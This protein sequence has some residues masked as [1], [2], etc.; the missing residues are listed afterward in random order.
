M[1]YTTK[2]LFSLF[3]KID[4]RDK[5]TAGKK[6]LYGILIAYVFSNTILAYNYF[7][8]FD[9]RSFVILTLTSNLFLI[10]IIVLSDFDNLLLANKSFE[11]LTTLPII[12]QQLFFSKFLSAVIFLMLFIS[13]S[14][15]P[16]II[17][18]Y[19][20]EHDFLKTAAYIF[21]NIVFSYFII[22][23]LIFIYGIV[24]NY[25]TSKASIVLAFVQVIFFIFVLYSS[26]LSSR[27]VATSKFFP[28]E[29]ILEYELMNFL[30]QTLFANAVYNSNY[31]IFCLSITSVILYLVYLFLS[32]KYFALINKLNSIGKKEKSGAGQRFTFIK[33]Y[34]LHRFVL[35][36]NYEVSSFN[37]ALYQLRNSRFLKI[38]YIPLVLIPILLV[39][40][41]ILSDIPQLLILNQTGKQTFFTTA[42]F[43]I[44]PSIT[45]TLIMSSRLLISN[46]KI[47]DENTSNTEWIYDSLP[48]GNKKIFIK[49]SVKF[50]YLYF[51]LPA[52]VTIL[53]LLS[54]NE[55]FVIVSLNILFIISALYL[56]SSISLLFDKIYPFTLESNKLKSASKFI[57]I[58]SALILGMIL[59]LI[60]IFVF[61]NII[62]V[63]I[64]I[65]F[66]ITLT[67]LINRNK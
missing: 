37:L 47:L 19:F 7:V 14:A 50:I 12:A 67:L 38:K 32:S 53:I 8:T 15:L 39:T 55:N 66:F 9:E 18:F 33:E 65:L 21:T 58:L 64:A 45:L 24:L 34:L 31:F 3:Q 6:K 11:I 5:D 40:I 35:F 23:V 28:K 60:Q 46:T 30:P 20:I 52:M 48:I 13:A 41:G 29:N 42:I 16:Q 10:V 44:S 49:G 54:L 51:I 27:L 62:F 43:I 22:G 1:S 17:F 25:F 63:V 26:T 36:S 4:Y 59:F 57:E 61:Q 2:A 56:I